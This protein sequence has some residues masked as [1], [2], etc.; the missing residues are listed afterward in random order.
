[1]IRNKMFDIY[2][3]DYRFLG[4]WAHQQ[5]SLELEV[6]EPSLWPLLIL[7]S[8]S[9]KNEMSSA[10]TQIF[11]YFRYFIESWGAER[12]ARPCRGLLERGRHEERPHRLRH[13]LSYRTLLASRINGAFI[14]APCRD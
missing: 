10:P 4:C 8:G 6:V 13:Q 12:E 3:Q 9:P 7:V 14:R 11:Y 2:F 1:M 5:A